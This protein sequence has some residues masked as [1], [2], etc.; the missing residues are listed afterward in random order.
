MSS[1]FAKLIV[2][3]LHNA[4]LGALSDELKGEADFDKVEQSY[5]RMNPL[6][7][8]HAP[9]STAAK[10]FSATVAEGSALFA[11]ITLH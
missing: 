9:A 4:G 6:R 7:M 2:Y 10:A 1:H 11:D 3:V 5:A 8:L